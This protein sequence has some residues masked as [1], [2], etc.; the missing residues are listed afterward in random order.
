M[1]LTE[2]TQKLEVVEVQGIEMA[3]FQENMDG[4]IY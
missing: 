1:R 4:E 2:I 3:E